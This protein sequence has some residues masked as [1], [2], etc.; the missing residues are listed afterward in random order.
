MWS[1]EVFDFFGLFS[2]ALV[3]APLE[4][5]SNAFSSSAD[6][7]AQAARTLATGARERIEGDAAG[8]LDASGEDVNPLF[9]EQPAINSAKHANKGNMLILIMGVEDTRARGAR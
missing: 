5:P 3:A 6:R 1:M 4:L 2:F 8:L 7:S 9:P